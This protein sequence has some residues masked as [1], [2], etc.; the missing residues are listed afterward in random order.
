MRATDWQG[1]EYGPG[2]IVLYP[3]QSGRSVTMVKAEVLDVYRVYHSRDT[4]KWERV[5]QGK[6]LVW[7]DEDTEL[8]VQVK[9]INSSRWKQHHGKDFYVDT[10]T[11]KRIDPWKSAR[12]WKNADEAGDYCTK[13]GARLDNGYSADDGCPGQRFPAGSNLRYHDELHRRHVSIEFCD[14]VERRHQATEKVTLTVT[15]NVTLL[16]SNITHQ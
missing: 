12:H 10:R 7:G 2:D 1:N 13:T 9:P 14:Y 16:T 15:E 6:T 3:A 5:I 11:D 4:Y 8:R